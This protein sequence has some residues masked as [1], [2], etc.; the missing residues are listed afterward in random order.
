M[1]PIPVRQI[2][3][4]K[5]DAAHTGRFSVRDI[6]K[7]LNGKDL[8]H[9]LHRHDF[10][11]IL[12]LQKGAGVHEI[13]FIRYEVEDH[14][15]FI[16]RPGQVHQLEL[17]V[18]STG[19][20][21]EFDPFFYRP[22]NTA[23]IQRWRKAV[24]RNH[25]R[26]EPGEFEKLHSI[27]GNIFYEYESK[28]EGYLDAIKAQLDLFFITYIRQSEKPQATVKADAAYA[29]DRFDELLR[30]LE[31]NIQHVKNAS[32]YAGMLNLSLYQL[33][34]ITKAAVGKTVSDLITE[35]IILEARRYLLAT[36]SQV[37]EIADI[38]GYE[39]VSYFIRFFRK[40]TGHSPEAF[41]KQFL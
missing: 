27:L 18:G 14:S 16:I 25:C 32:D 39:D 38:L 1:K 36:T 20:L 40:H 13:D 23:A 26:M 34:A 21:L 8:V 6:Q 37:K 24:S 2:T 7:I 15:L 3:T 11:F 19:L 30:L 28:D 35:Q 5:V 29:Q 9:R 31:S 4:A 17:A 10:F 12:S 22:E 41:R 33:N